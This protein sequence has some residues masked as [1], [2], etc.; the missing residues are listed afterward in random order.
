MIGSVKARFA[1]DAVLKVNA[2]GLEGDIVEAGVWKGGATMAMVLANMKHNTDRHFWLFDTF[3]G[4]PPPGKKDDKRSH[5]VWEQLT[6][7]A[8]ASKSKGQKIRFVESG[9]LN[10]GPKAVVSNNLWLA[11]IGK[12]M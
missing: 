9:K 2:M 8:Y 3:E 11:G 12:S 1:W 7:G 6:T 10:Y 5:K 4:L